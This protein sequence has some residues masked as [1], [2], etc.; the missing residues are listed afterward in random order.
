M[1]VF[2]IVV[3]FVIRAAY[4]FLKLNFY[5]WFKNMR[6][7]SHEYNTWEYA[8]FFFILII[9]FELFPL[10]MFLYNLNYI[11]S[12]RVALEPKQIKNYNGSRIRYFF[13]FLM[14]FRQVRGSDASA[15][16]KTRTDNFSHNQD[17]LIED[18]N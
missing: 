14:L 2:V 3:C 10:S 12:N 9:I 15:L 18:F 4:D 5:N 11:M 17:S 7:H 6:E 13:N 8:C 16:K 1:N